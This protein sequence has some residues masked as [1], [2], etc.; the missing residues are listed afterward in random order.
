[1]VPKCRQS[2]AIVLRGLAAPNRKH[3]LTWFAVLGILLILFSLLDRFGI[4]FTCDTALSL[5]LFCFFGCLCRIVLVLMD[6]FNA[7]DTE[8]GIFGK[9][10]LY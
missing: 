9:S 7:R 6:F 1:M 5:A 2:L 8:D 3:T 10:S 4:R